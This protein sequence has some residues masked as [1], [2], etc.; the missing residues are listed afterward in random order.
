MNVYVGKCKYALGKVKME[1]QLPD[2]FIERRRGVREISDLHNELDLHSGLKISRGSVGVLK[3]LRAR[4]CL[5]STSEINFGSPS[6]SF[7]RTLKAI[8]NDQ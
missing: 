3:F 6:K 1:W 5:A 8:S 2:L 4:P 7:S